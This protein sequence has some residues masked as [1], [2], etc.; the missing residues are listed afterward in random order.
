MTARRRAAQASQKDATLL[1]NQGQFFSV[2]ANSAHARTLAD[3]SPVPLSQPAFFVVSAR[4]Y[5]R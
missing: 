2:I 4:K 3:S 5:V 1:F